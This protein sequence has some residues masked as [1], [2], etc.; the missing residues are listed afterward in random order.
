MHASGE[1]PNPKIDDTWSTCL[2][3]DGI[4]LL[5]WWVLPACVALVQVC[6]RRAAPE[7]PE[8]SRDGVPPE[9]L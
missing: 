5:R 6:G 3:K 9:F 7:K 4:E 2:W 1:D 8:L